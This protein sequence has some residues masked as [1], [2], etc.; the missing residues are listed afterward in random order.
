MSPRQLGALADE[1]ERAG[2]AELR[3]T[4][5]RSVLVPL[6]AS[7]GAHALA[8]VLGGTGFVLD[9]GDPA[10]GVVACAGA[11]GCASAHAATLQDGARVVAALR[12]RAASGPAPTVHLSGC[13][14]RCA[15]RRAHDVT[16]VAEPGG[17][18]VVLPG[19]DADADAGAR[20]G[21][22]GERL[23]ATGLS[24][25]DALAAAGLAA[26]TATATATANDTTTTEAP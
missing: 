8:G 25:D 21:S 10:A 11:P 15:S 17:Y 24:L 14:K 23:A 9:P 16:L 12:R 5:G 18:A 26:A 7:G 1:A 2:G 19:P 13:A 22:G 3:V 20:A 4:A 6:A